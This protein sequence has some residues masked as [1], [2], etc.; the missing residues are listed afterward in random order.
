MIDRATSDALGRIA[1]RAS[2]ALGSYD[3]GFEPALSDATTRATRWTP[4]LD[5]LSVAAPSGD[6]FVSR[7][8]TGAVRYSRDGGFV[9]ANGELRTR[10]GAAVLGVPAGST[11][12]TL[13]P[14]RIDGVDA[15]LGRVAA[16]RIDADGTVTAERAS[17]DPRTG[18]R[19]V[20]RV[21]LG[22]IALARFPAGSAPERIDATH[23]R[24]PGGVAPAL[25]YPGTGDRGALRVGARDLGRLDTVASLERLSEAYQEFEALSAAG[26]ARGKLGR[27]AMDLLK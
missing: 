15:V 16:A 1:A 2:D 10:D 13:A 6:Y 27:V 21:V 11:S 14:L 25:G 7:D 26:G 4:S 9:F 17:I 8:A 18:E 5:P 19:R 23:V 22:R 12:A 24:A 3:A 20:E